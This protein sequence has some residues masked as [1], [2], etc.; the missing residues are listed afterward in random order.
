M[1]N[2][3]KIVVLLLVLFSQI[4]K[5]TAQVVPLCDTIPCC[6]SIVPNFNVNLTGNPDSV[7]LSPA[8][9]R[10]GLC[11]DNFS[12]DRCISF[13]ITLD[14]SAIG[15]IFDIYSGA[16]PPGAL[17][18]RINC[19]TVEY[20]VGNLACLSG[21]GP[22]VLTFCKPGANINVYSIASVPGR[23]VPDTARTVQGCSVTLGVD[24]LIDST[25]VWTDITS[26]TGAYNSLLSCTTGCDTVDFNSVIGL[27]SIIEYEVC[28]VIQTPHCEIDSIACDTVIVFVVPPLDA[29][30]VADTPTLCIENDS[31]RYLHAITTG[32]D[33]A[34]IYQWFQG[35]PDTGLLVGTDSVYNVLTGGLYSLVVTDT[36]YPACSTDTTYTIVRFFPPPVITIPSDTSVCPNHEVVLTASGADILNWFT[37]TDTLCLDCDSI[38]YNVTSN[39]TIYIEGIDSSGCTSIDSFTTNIYPVYSVAVFDTICDNDT[40]TLPDGVVTSSQGVYVDTLPTVYGCDSIITTHLVVY[41]AFNIAVFDT[42]CDNEIYTLP[43]GSTTASPGTYVDSFLTVFGCD[44]VITTTLTVHPTFAIAV[45]D[46]ICDND[47]YTLP[48]GSMTSIAGV[49]IDT[50]PTI[51]GCDS[52]ITTYLTVHPTFAIA[53]FDTICDNGSY[54]LPDGTITSSPGIYVD[55]LVTANGCDSIITTS[56]TVYPTFSFTVFDTICDNDVYTLP[57]GSTTSTQNTYVHS[58]ATVNGCD[59]IITTHLTVHSTFSIAVFDTI[60]DDGTYTLPDGNVISSPGTYIDTL[61]T[62]QGCDSVITT[63][64]TVN[65]TFNIAVFDTICDNGSYTL[66]DGIITSSPGTYIDT[67]FTV[68]GCDSIITTSLTVHPTFSFTV[69]DTICDNDVYTLPDGSTTSTQNT[70]VHSFTTINGCDSIITT[71]LTVHATYTV[72]VFDT[73]CDDGFYTLPNGVITSTSGIYT[74]TLLT[75]HGCDSVITTHLTVNPTFNIAVFD[76]ICDNGSYMLPNGSVTSTAGVYIDTLFTVNGCDSIITTSLT[77]HPTFSFTVFDTICDNDVYTL[78]DGSTTSTQNTYVHSLATVNGCD[79]I[80]T[81]HLTVHATF[82]V[83]VFDT[84]CD[85]G[86]YTLPDGI[87]TSLPGTYIDTLFTLNGCDS[88]ITTHLTVNPTFNIAVFDTICDN[89]S[90]TLPD[91]IITSSSGTYIDTLFTV[92]GCDSI[93]TTSLTVHPT[94]S[95]T[96]FD[97]ICDND[98]YTLPDGSTTSIQNTYVHSFATVNGCDSIITTHLTVHATFSVAVFDT[99]CDD[100]FYTL[101]NGVI[102][103]TSGI[104][105]D[106]LF[107]A[108]GCDSVITTSL[109]VHPTFAIAVFDTICDNDTYT[110]PDGSMTS[111]AGIYIDTL[112]TIYGCDSIITTSLTV[113]PTYAFT[114]FD[115]ICY[116]DVYTLPDGSTTSTQNTYVHS[117][118]TIN[119]C[120]SII[121]THLTV[122]ATFSVAVFDTICD[123]GTYTLPD[124]IVTSLPGT[125][126]DT[127]FTIHGCDSVITTH[128]T[129]N[130]TFNIA[131]FDTICDNGSYTLPNGSVT[132]TAGVYIDTLPTI[133]GC[134]SIVTTS[135]TVHPTFSFTVFDT[136]CY[137]DV[138]TLPDGSTTS[139]QNTYVHSFATINGC[140]SIITTHLTVH[141]TFTIAVFDTICDDGTYTLPDGIVT[142]LPGTYI[143]T[144]FT[145]HGCDSVITTHLTVN[146]TFNIA[147]FDTIC[148]NGSYTL[149]DGMVTS[150][151]GTYIDTLFTVNGCDSIITTSLVVHPTFSFTVFD[152]ICDNDV[153]TLPD[154]ST[155]SIQNTYVHSFATINGCDSIIT[156]H[157]TVHAT[158][159]VEV[160]DTICDD[161]TYTLPNGVIT[162]T[163]GIYTDT[164]F[165]AN[166]C[167]SVITTSLTVHPTYAVAVFD[168]ICDNGSYTLPD[169]IITSSS[170]TYI[171]TLFT[172]NGCDSIVT[173]SLTVHPTYAF[174]DSFDICFGDTIILPGGESIF[175]D[176]SIIH[177]YNTIYACDS[178]R[179]YV[180]TI[181]NTSYT[182]LNAVIC[183][184][185]T[186]TVGNNTYNSSGIYFDTLLNIQGCDSIIELEL[187]VHY[188]TYNSIDTTICEGATLTVGEYRFTEAGQYIVSYKDVF[189]CDS[190]YYVTLNLWD[191]PM[192]TAREDTTIYQGEAVTAYTI[193]SY[194]DSLIFDWFINGSEICLDCE[195]FEYNYFDEATVSVWV[196]DTNQC[197]SGDEFEVMMKND[198]PEDLITVPNIISPNNDGFNDVF[199]IANPHNVDIEIVRIFN[200]W[201]EMVYEATGFSNPWDGSFRNQACNPGV[202]TYYLKGVCVSGSDFMKKGNITLLK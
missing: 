75:I 7:Y 184:G 181:H 134:D 29:Q 169:G 129:V 34:Y 104:Y 82:S 131:V 143:D 20:P 132:S 128:L 179:R 159:T 28:G 64:L 112:P 12:P 156:T 22:H 166:G 114:V 187:Y 43:D 142:S 67:L 174:V 80:I 74:D 119:G 175:S 185:E 26:G 168:T 186:I 171:D 183:D 36:L 38:L 189:G 42:I 147:V 177:T 85:D 182:L 164:L 99:I 93:V 127:L 140:D 87:V 194:P 191:L 55:T 10:E 146:P 198:C 151:S 83:A 153:Y 90:Y 138:Y 130:P 9:S 78:P 14:S 190:I 152:T 178:T 137:N 27:P 98:V 65:P 30:I 59:S 70:Y 117:F 118:A 62:A 6:D 15:V 113:H 111:I 61:F 76:T 33:S 13:V 41:L 103:S 51:Y 123:D 8:V 160:F 176:T 69:F 199:N 144:L 2:V 145:I 200:R 50:L 97:T 45:F 56:L 157:L 115:T 17:F 4:N 54:T 57:D 124:G 23:I 180:V 141:A 81:T 96:V 24:G 170:G 133:Y 46:T 3:F 21:P 102:T 193:F 40:Y 58:L 94:F 52:V 5:T 44:S 196:T 120:D 150:S 48:D 188:P 16:E 86:T 172:V 107:T 35:T 79:S 108:N 148:D 53:I 32:N 161:G 149:P 126:I 201:G 122:H 89:G 116:N 92:N 110:L 25:V 60:C 73:I 84:I 202:F 47:T 11:C 71:H 95:F 125:Y 1:G 121:T 192:V 39:Q 154:G 135:L 19:D 66:P 173:T 162:S 18:Y 101:P 136:I 106:T 195:T 72:A 109:T 105:T 158:Y 100:G 155:T 197:K 68:N 163:S 88:V 77:V 167:D 91:G 63:H 139:I 165:T 31:S 49:Y 37:I